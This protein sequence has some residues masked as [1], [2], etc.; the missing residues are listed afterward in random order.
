MIVFPN[1]KINIGLNITGKRPDGYHNLQTIF[2]PIAIRDALEVI[3]NE[4]AENPVNFTNSGNPVFS[5]PEDNLCVK[6]FE[7]LKK[8]FPGI[9]PVHM[10]LHKVIPMGAGLGGGS[11]DAAF[12][13][14][15]LNQQFEL[16]LSA[17][18]L[19]RY[20]LQLG[21]DCPFFIINKPCYATGRG[22]QLA[23]VAL[24]LSA[25]KILLINPGI[26]VSTADA[27][28]HISIAQNFPYL[29]QLIQAPVQQWKDLVVNDFEKT[30]FRK[31]PEVGDIKEKLY[32]QGALY[33]SMSGSG[34]SVYGIFQRDHIPGPNFPVHYFCQWV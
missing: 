1:G 8:D 3:V 32:E 28:S 2:Y 20:S 33:A 9:P 24:D 6:A 7:I 12:V 25:Y 34:S 13:L 30:V 4:G 21:S 16:K 29:Q 23:E 5:E 19:I 18:K 27:F 10:H 14:K 26:H 31:F 11:A 22:E 15:L 17:E